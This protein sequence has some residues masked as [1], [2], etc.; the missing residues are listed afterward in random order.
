MPQNLHVVGALAWDRQPL[1]AGEAESHISVHCHR[2]LA[3]P[4]TGL[5]VI[6][7]SIMP[8][9]YQQWPE[10]VDFHRME[11]MEAIPELSELIGPPP[12]TLAG[13]APFA[14]RTRWYGTLDGPGYQPG[15]RHVL[16]RVC[17]A[18]LGSGVPAASP[19]LRWRAR[20]PT[21]RFEEF[22]A[23][24]VRRVG[25]DIWPVVVGSNGNLRPV[26][27]TALE[28]HARRVD[29]AGRADHDE[30]PL[31]RRYVDSDGTADDPRAYAAYLALGPAERV[32]LHD[33]RAQELEDSGAWA[34]RIAALPFH[35]ERGSDP[36]GA[37]VVALL[38]AAQN[39]TVGR[40]HDRR[41]GSPGEA[42][43]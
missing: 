13:D 43:R 18:T 41:S 20:T 25:A 7:T 15:S 8:G 12:P 2:W 26:L 39:C 30:T 14:E 36:A 9:A 6:L 29:A 23:L 34:V 22:I 40:F 11:L 4:Y 16:A 5:D 38:K 19:H 32:A 42:G 10:L 35:R 17:A 24:F 3:G 21:S 33:R 1:L 28:Q 37:G 27:A 31:A